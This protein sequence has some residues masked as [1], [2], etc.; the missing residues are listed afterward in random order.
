MKKIFAIVTAMILF[1]CATA[2]FASCEE[3]GVT[4]SMRNADYWI[5][6]TQDADKL[7]MSAEDIAQF[8]A[9]ICANPATHCTDILAFAD[10]VGAESVKNAISPQKKLLPKN[11]VDGS[12][13]TQNFLDSVV[14]ECN[15]ESISDSLK[16]RFAFA[17]ENLSVRAL[18]TAKAS[19]KTLKN[20]LFDRYTVSS[21][22]VWEPLAVL[23]SSASGKWCFVRAKNCEGWVRSEGLAFCDRQ[24]LEKYIAMP[25]IVVTDAKIYPREGLAGKRWEMLLGTR[26]PLSENQN[27][28]VGEVASHTSYVVLLPENDENGNFKTRELL[29]PQSAD[30]HEGWLDYTQ[31]NL[32]RIAFKLLGEPYG[33]GGDFAQ[34]DCSAL[35]HDVYSVFGF[36][37]PRN[38][39]VQTRIPSFHADT[40]KYSD[41]EKEKLLS[42]L[43]AGAFV[44]MPGHIMLYIGTARGKPYILHEAYALY[45]DSN[46]KDEL[47]MNCAVVSDM[48]LYRS[49]GKKVIS[50]IEN[51]NAIK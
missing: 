11:F 42:T 9:K 38:S 16:V 8:N 29:I 6:R 46:K 49:N 14:S 5:L 22:K 39:A 2:A 48:E 47:L 24:T 4:K 3:L 35:I 41:I 30:I 27:T 21:I 23:H 43:P 33:W 34:W 45:K 17:N 40:K 19:Y 7:L 25:F 20:Q 18:P 13:V 1:S 26:L 37:L 15:I 50:C 36:D 31:A 51:I 44:Q 12:R 32:L 28:V 10:T